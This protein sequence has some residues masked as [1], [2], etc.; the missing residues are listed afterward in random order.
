MFEMLDGIPPGVIGFEAV[1]KIEADDYQTSLE[2]AITAAAKTRKIKVV[3]VIGERYEGYSASASWEDAK[4]GFEHFKA[5]ERAA[6]VTDIEWMKHVSAMFGWMV[7]G[8]FKVFSLAEL[9]DAKAWAAA[10]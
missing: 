4:F 2:P 10:D 9:D 8:K 7:P 1:G 3:Y 6:L 5:W